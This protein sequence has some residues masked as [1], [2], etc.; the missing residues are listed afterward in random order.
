MT[1]R[2]YE[3][4]TGQAEDAGGHGTAAKRVFASPSKLELI[5]LV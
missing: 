2:W 3:A 1:M 4:V 5:G